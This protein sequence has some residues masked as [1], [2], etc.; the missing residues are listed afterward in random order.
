MVNDDTESNRTLAFKTFFTKIQKEKSIRLLPSRNTG[1]LAKL[2][3]LGYTQALL[4]TK[5]SSHL[6]KCDFFKKN[7]NRLAVQLPS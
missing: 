3:D 1:R 6:R 5:K 7:F 4:L 2:I